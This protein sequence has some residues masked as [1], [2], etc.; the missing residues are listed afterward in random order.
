MSRWGIS[1]PDGHLP[2]LAIHAIARLLYQFL[3]RVVHYRI[4]FYRNDSISV[5][6]TCAA[7]AY[8]GDWPTAAYVSYTEHVSLSYAAD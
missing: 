1:S 4:V 7:V 6:I 3:A 2:A 5:L 8:F